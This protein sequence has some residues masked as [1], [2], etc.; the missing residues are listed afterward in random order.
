M[1]VHQFI[2]Y[3]LLRTECL[4]ILF[5]HNQTLCWS[6]NYNNIWN[7]NII[8]RCTKTE[9]LQNCISRNEYMRDDKAGFLTIFELYKIF[10]TLLFSSI[11]NLCITTWMLHQIFLYSTKV[12]YSQLAKIRTTHPTVSPLPFPSYKMNELTNKRGPF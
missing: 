10:F 6:Q 3:C 12:I 7:D 1:D 11:L 4:K 9:Y 2:I 5:L 8:C